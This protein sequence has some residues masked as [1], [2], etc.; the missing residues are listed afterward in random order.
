M[1]TVG[2]D[3]TELIIKKIKDVKMYFISSAV[4]LDEG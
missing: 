3:E 1:F 4:D 2:E